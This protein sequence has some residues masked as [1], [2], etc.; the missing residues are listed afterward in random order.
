MRRRSEFTAVNVG[1]L[2]IGLAGYP[3]RIS[4]DF[5]AFPAGMAVILALVL[6][7]LNFHTHK[8]ARTDPAIALKGE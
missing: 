2:A 8:A 1:G 5:W 6:M 4:T 3:F 7:T